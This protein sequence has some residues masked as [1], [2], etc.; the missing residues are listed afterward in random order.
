[1]FQ[2]LFARIGERRSVMQRVAGVEQVLGFL[3]AV[4]LLAMTV[5]LAEVGAIVVSP[6]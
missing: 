5:V 4:A 3:D 2:H 6:L 1:M